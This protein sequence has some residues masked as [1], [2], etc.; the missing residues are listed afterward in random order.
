M[1]K[2]EDH[3]D[4][5]IP[6]VLS[7][8]GQKD[9]IK[10]D[11]YVKLLMD[12]VDK[13]TEYP[14]KVYIIP[15]TRHKEEE[16]SLEELREYFNNRKNSEKCL[17]IQVIPS[18][19]TSKELNDVDDKYTEVDNRMVGVSSFNKS[20]A[21]QTGIKAGNGKYVCILD[22]DCAV[23]NEWTQHMIPLSEEYFFVSAMWRNDIKIARDQFLFYKRSKFDEVDLIPDCTVA[24]TSGNITRYAEDNNLEFYICIN[25][26]IYSNPSLRKYH[27]LDIEDGEQ[28]YINSKPFLHHFRKGSAREENTKSKWRE[29]VIKYLETH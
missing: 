8:D 2:Y 11:D 28:I 3:I 13:Y 1:K 7:K 19:N 17:D 24:D 10:N 12:S 14:Y 23:L 26:S 21:H 4:I 20:L 16:Q 22:Y 6:A 15:E 25:S 29:E 9:G 5:V 27:V 18:M